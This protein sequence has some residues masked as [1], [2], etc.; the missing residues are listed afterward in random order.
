MPLVCRSTIGVAPRLYASGAGD[1]SGGEI[2]DELRDE[3]LTRLEAGK[4]V[5]VDIDL[6]AYEQRPNVRNR[7]SIRFRDESLIAMG[8]TGKGKPFLRDHEQRDSLAVAGKIISSKTTKLGEGHYEIRMRARLTA[9]F[10]VDLALRDLLTAVSIGWEPTGDVICS[11]CAKPVYTVCYHWPGDRVTE[12]PQSDGSKKYL[13]DRNG[14]LVVE[15]IYTNADLI[16]TSLSPIGGVKLAGVEGIRAALSAAGLTQPEFPDDES[17]PALNADPIAADKSTREPPVPQPALTPE[18]PQMKIVILTTAQHAHYLTLSSDEQ[19]AFLE[20]TSAQRD[21]DVA[22]KLSADP[23]IWKGEL[24]GVEVRKSDGVLAL[25]LATANEDSVKQQRAMGLQLAAATEANTLAAF[26]LRASTEL[27]HIAGTEDVKV[28][29]LRALET[30]P[31]VTVRA[32]ALLSLKSAD[33]LGKDAAIPKGVNPGLSPADGDPLAAFNAGVDA[34]AKANGIK[35]P[36]LALEQF[37]GTPEGRTLKK[38]YD[39]TRGYGQRPGQQPG[40]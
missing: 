36:G 5:A 12:T 16:E 27:A 37:L 10:A 8:A 15:W 9:R 25:Q 19:T 28:A 29:I 14:V 32:S 31:D 13:R 26:R 39:A 40:N 17:L 38:T 30:I 11:A 23:P 22:A 1:E 2:T 3:L 4:Y 24:T 34:F 7:N 6:L 21:A 35:D 33:A 20:K 18:K